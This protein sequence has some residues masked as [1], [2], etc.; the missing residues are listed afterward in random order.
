MYSK[1]HYQDKVKDAV[2]AKQH[3]SS[4]PD[5]K[6][7]LS[8]IKQQTKQAFEE[9]SKEVRDKV[10]AAVEAMKE[11]KCAE[12]Q[13]A[14]G[15]GKS[16]VNKEVQTYPDFTQSIM[17]PYTQFVECVFSK[18]ALLTRAKHS[19][20]STSVSGPVSGMSA[21]PPQMLNTANHVLSFEEDFTYKNDDTL[22]GI[23]A[24]TS[25]IIS[26]PALPV[27]HALNTA[28]QMPLFKQDFTFNQNDYLS[29]AATPQIQEHNP[30]DMN[31]FPD[32]PPKPVE[33]AEDIE[34]MQP[35]IWVILREPLTMKKTALLPLLPLASASFPAQSM[36]P[37]APL[38]AMNTPEKEGR[39]SKHQK[40]NHPAA[41]GVEIGH[42][43]QNLGG[44]ETTTNQKY[45]FNSIPEKTVLLP[46]LPLASA[47]FLVQSTP[48]V[49]PP[50]VTNAPE[51]EGR[52]LKHQKKNHPAAEGATRLSP[53]VESSG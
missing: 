25:P 31:F 30:L 1:I 2:I 12:M 18:A 32:F 5:K 24:D 36:P 34:L 21:L 10:F 14:G 20:P 38:P 7:L 28:S 45:V 35:L 8:V 42:Q 52:P 40:T 43:F 11:K 19:I 6:S 50:P 3:L 27:H 48:P 23:T 49:I 17:A 44:F 53:V 39:P 47:S 33:T 4:K 9:E 29:E 13:G 15:Q 37:F 26:G 16:D 41:E 51:Q 22:G 46:P